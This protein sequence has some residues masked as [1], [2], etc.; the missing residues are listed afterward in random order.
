[1]K[2]LYLSEQSDIGLLKKA[3]RLSVSKW[4]IREIK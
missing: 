4:E 3:T 2:A 1:M